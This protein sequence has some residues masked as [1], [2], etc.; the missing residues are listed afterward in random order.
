MSSSTNFDFT[1]TDKAPD[2]DLGSKRIPVD[3]YIDPA[4]LKL[5][6]ANIWSKT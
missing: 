2:P 6:D 5:E 1:P 4:Y 3:R